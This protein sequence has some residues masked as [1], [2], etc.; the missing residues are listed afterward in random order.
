M[1]V[2]I[3]FNV[4]FQNWIVNKPMEMCIRTKCNVNPWVTLI[5][6]YRF[7]CFVMVALN[8]IVNANFWMNW[9]RLCYTP[10][11]ADEETIVLQM[12]WYE[13]KIKPMHPHCLKHCTFVFFLFC[14]CTIEFIFYLIFFLW[15]SFNFCIKYTYLFKT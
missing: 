15:F 14:C 9:E 11:S 7:L 5:N 1:S 4:H 13:T 12:N 10:H 3:F 8:N 6:W 2:L